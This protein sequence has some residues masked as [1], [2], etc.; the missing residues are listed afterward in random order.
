MLDL[1]DLVKHINSEQTSL[2]PVTFFDEN[3]LTQSMSLLFSEAFDR[4]NGKGGEGI[5]K[6]KQAMGGGKT[7]CMV[8][9]GLL[10]NNPEVR[11]VV[12]G[13][14]YKEM[15]NKKVRVVAF[16]GRE[17]DTPLGIWG[18]IASQLGKKNVFT[19]YYSPLQAPGQSA[20]INLLKSDKPLLILLDELPP[21]LENAK[22]KQIGNS[23]L[24]SVTVT[25]LSNLFVAINAP[26]LSNVCIVISDLNA[27]YE[28][29]TDQI[30][31]ITRSVHDI[32]N[33]NS[34]LSRSVFELEPVSLNSDDL[35]QILKKRV[36]E[37]L[38][39][40][41]DIEEVAADYKKALKEAVQM[42]LLDK[43]PEQFMT[44]IKSSYPFHPA[45]RDLYA[46][47]RE[48][49]GFQQTRGMIRLVSSIVANMFREGGD[50]DTKYLIAPH[51]FNLNDHATY[52]NIQKIN[53]NLAD[54]IS[55]DIAAKGE[56]AA[57]QYDAN[58]CTTDATDIC[59]LLLVSSL[60]NV[61]LAVKGLRPNEITFYL[62]SPG[63][64]LSQ[65][66]NVI[67]YLET[68]TCWYLHRGT[69]E[70]LFFKK[71][72]NL[73]AKINSSILSYGDDTAK[74]EIKK[75]L[76]QFFK[77]TLKDCYQEVLVFPPVNKI[78]ISPDHVTLIIYEPLYVGLHPDLEQFFAD[79][80]YKNRVLF[81]SGSR[82]MMSSLL[83]SAKKQL[84]IRA[85]KAELT[86]EGVRSDDPQM[87]S[88]NTL[89][90]NALKAMNGIAKETFTSLSYPINQDG[91][92]VIKSNNEFSMIFEHNKYD[93]EI[94]IRAELL[95]RKKFENIDK[96]DD[97]FRK[98][99]EQRIFTQKVMPWSD[100]KN[101]AATNAHWPWYHPALLDNLKEDLVTKDQWRKE[102]NSINKGPF[103][104][105]KSTVRVRE[106]RHDD[107]TGEA[108][109]ELIPVHGDKVYYEYDAPA[110]TGSS[111]VDDLKSFKTSAMCIYFLCVD[112]KGE[113]KPGDQTVWNNKITLK[114]QIYGNEFGKTVE[115]VTAPAN[116]K[117]KYTTD[118]SD[119]LQHGAVYDGQF[120]INHDVS[121][122]LVIAESNGIQSNLIKEEI[123]WT[124][125]GGSDGDGFKNDKPAIWNHPHKNPTTHES[126]SFI[127]DLRKHDAKAK[128]VTIEIGSSLWSSL[129]V[130]KDV[131]LDYTQLETL[132]EA[133]KCIG[134]DGD[135]SLTCEQI[136]FENGQSLLDFANIMKQSVNFEEVTQ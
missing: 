81:L 61:P 39:D 126:Y 70:K 101:R 60:A 58:H 20:W 120:T 43:S 109:L 56:A 82:N 29:G 107:N 13:D 71:N 51:D 74:N 47:F 85:A 98:K 48:N 94:Q 31:E 1:N 67:N 121:H 131:S 32:N 95:N 78:H 44:Q 127:E 53:S 86:Q 15:K 21:Y 52:S 105:P 112:S 5:I 100:V 30:E 104:A 36:F 77:P 75:Y 73:L 83:E 65:I 25:A 40:K 64:D 33:L 38:P 46:R 28:S 135:I 99:C 134:I 35:Y 3:Y 132:I 114:Y 19:D 68:Q 76:E 45:T 55:H 22:S 92:S 91:S 93:G 63:R 14:K 128:T 66:N 27:T 16:T 110:T 6:L 7:H 54:A 130:C 62:C 17:S 2:D 125:A 106:S 115:L 11:P 37:K 10:A 87:E 24:S 129:S 88:A 57:E 102:G 69:D 119:P 49:P 113:H 103:E 111:Q 79:L 89:Y 8:A 26:E 97:A 136:A 59:N 84:A 96:P 72:Q 90:E 50:A 4:F 122:V 117:I 18:A 34:E 12:F 116:A 123:D 9:L 80:E 133:L 41:T 42:G 108:T 124:S 23:D 118:G